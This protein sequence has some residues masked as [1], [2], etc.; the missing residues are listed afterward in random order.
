MV[1]RFHEKEGWDE[2]RQPPGAA[3]EM[4]RVKQKDQKIGKY[5]DGSEQVIGAL[6]EVHRALGPGLLE[7]AY[8]A[9]VCHELGLRGLAFER[10]RPVGIA[11][12]G[13]II[14]CGYRID[15]LVE[16][17]IIVELKSIE[18]LLPLHAAQILTY[19]KLSAV[20]AGLL[21]NFNVMSLRQGLRRLSLPPPQPS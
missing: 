15:V 4:E 6:I 16:G 2:C 8:E 21:V 10:Q 17:R 5:E 12:K 9:C 13:L 11:Y 7:S 18:P 1:P 19:M 3:V 14:D 20:S